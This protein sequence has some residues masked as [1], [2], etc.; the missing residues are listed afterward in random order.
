MIEVSHVIK[1]LGK[2]Y[3][4]ENASIAEYF[5]CEASMDFGPFKKGQ[6]IGWM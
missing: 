4:H 6:E 3:Y 2:H 1:C 5:D